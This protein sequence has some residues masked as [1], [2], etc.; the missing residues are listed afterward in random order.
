MDKKN[1]SMRELLE[2]SIDMASY[3]RRA[4]EVILSDIF[5]RQ[6]FKNVSIE[7]CLFKSILRDYCY[8]GLSKNSKRRKHKK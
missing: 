5:S 8:S 1:F 6:R 2:E 3:Y 7:D 4:G